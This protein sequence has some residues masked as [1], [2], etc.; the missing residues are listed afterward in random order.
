[1]QRDELNPAKASIKVA[2]DYVYVLFIMIKLL[3]P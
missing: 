1:M 2:I 3:V